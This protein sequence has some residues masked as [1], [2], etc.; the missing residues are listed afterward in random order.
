MVGRLHGLQAPLPYEL[1]AHYTADT[2][3]DKHVEAIAHKILEEK[4]MR[5]EWFDVSPE[6]AKQAINDAIDRVRQGERASSFSVGPKKVYTVRR[7]IILTAEMDEELKAYAKRHNVSV[8]AVIRA[9]LNV[10]KE[11]EW[12]VAENKNG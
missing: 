6:D 10:V 11:L 12:P 8:S 4:R 3:F 2:A 5:G 9:R 7:Q 1:A